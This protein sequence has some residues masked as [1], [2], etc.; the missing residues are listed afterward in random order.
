MPV[1]QVPIVLEGLGLDLYCVGFEPL[2]EVRGHGDRVAVDV[3]ALP[4]V[5]ASLIAC[6]LGV[7][8]R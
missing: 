4:G 2:V 6:G 8:L 1:D 7:L 5:Y 3:L